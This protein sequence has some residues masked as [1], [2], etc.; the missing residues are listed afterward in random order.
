[1]KVI[2]LEEIKGTGGEGDVVEVKTGYAVNHLFPKKLA[3]SATT[4]NL[5]Q[6]ELRKHNIAKR[7]AERLDTADKIIAA[8]DGKTIRVGAKVGEEGQLFG[9]ITPSQVADALNERFGLSLDRRRI[10]LHGSI[11]TAGEHGATIS[12]YRETKATIT[13]EVVDEK[14]LLAPVEV[15]VEAAVE[16]EAETEVVDAVEAEAEVVAAAET[17]AIAE[18]VAKVEA[19]VA[20]EEIE[21]AFSAA[22][23]ALDAAVADAVVTEVEAAEPEE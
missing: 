3:V 14:T 18:A 5:K 9:S 12:I 15:E 1:M 16:A 11:K 2:L 10:D 8:L 17:E 21:E 19:E 4:G 13:V 7:E 22:E 6:L 20:A 23:G